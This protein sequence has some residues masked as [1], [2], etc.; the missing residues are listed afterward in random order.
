[1]QLTGKGKTPEDRVKILRKLSG[2]KEAPK[3]KDREKKPAK[4]AEKHHKANGATPGGKP[5]HAADTGKKVAPKQPNKAAAAAV[6]HAG[7]AGARRGHGK[8]SVAAKKSRGRK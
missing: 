2:I 4:A 5:E 7:K 1:M 6:R 3:K 8:R